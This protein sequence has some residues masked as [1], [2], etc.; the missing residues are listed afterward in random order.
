MSSGGAWEVV[1]DK[2]ALEVSKYLTTTTDPFLP[3]SRTGRW[4]LALLD[5]EALRDVLA[6]RNGGALCGMIGCARGV[7]GG[8]FCSEKCA[9]AFAVVAAAVPSSLVSGRAE[10]VQA[11][12]GLFPNLSF[13]ALQRLAG[14]ESAS[15]A[16][17]R[18]RNGEEEQKA[19][20]S[21]V[22]AQWDAWGRGVR[23][24]VGESG[25]PRAGTT[26]PLP[27][28]VCDWVTTITTARTRDIFA[29]LCHGGSL[30]SR[31]WEESGA[32]GGGDGS[33][34]AKYM[35]PI[36]ALCLQRANEKL[37]LSKDQN[38]NGEDVREEDERSLVNPE[39]QRQRL[40]LFARH[41][42]SPGTTAALS[43]LLLYD[44][45]TLEH[46]W[47]V[48]HSS[49]LLSSLQFPFVLP[50]LFVT[51][52]VTPHMLFLA[53]VMLAAVGLCVPAV[54]V[55]WTRQDDTCDADRNTSAF[56]EVMDALGVAADDVVACVKV[57]V[58]E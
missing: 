11:V 35:Q 5:T 14:A 46:A 28:M 51:S 9:A 55:E 12:G 2:A 52:S 17:I 1:V 31:V 48:W 39:L 54:W 53:L 42:F 37:R 6:E 58:L 38:G 30:S 45:T 4:M 8:Q 15:V 26:L 23:Q 29:R 32:V 57:L 13:A 47:D 33:L 34:Y 7:S 40:A 19:A 36:R 16:D 10:A 50:S 20:L 25:G 3:D 41:I 18:E 44:E 27:L 49:G 24:V 22:E 56:A 43:R 21:G